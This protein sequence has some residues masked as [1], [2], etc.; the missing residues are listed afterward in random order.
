MFF[1]KANLPTNL[2]ASRN[3]YLPKRPLTSN[4]STC[5]R[6][7]H[8]ELDP[9]LQQGSAAAGRRGIHIN[10]P[11][12]A[13]CLMW[14]LAGAIYGPIWIDINMFLHLAGLAGLM[15]ARTIAYIEIHDEVSFR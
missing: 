12:W 10:A 3:C 7:C 1:P 13:A 11:H 8:A 2:S 5:L 4:P 15:C 6:P 9:K 14:S